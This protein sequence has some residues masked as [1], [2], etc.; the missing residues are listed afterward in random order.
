MRLEEEGKKGFGPLNYAIQDKK[1]IE[2]I[3]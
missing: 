1:I 3:P 2:K